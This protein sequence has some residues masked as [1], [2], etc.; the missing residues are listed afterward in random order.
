MVI[1]MMINDIE[2]FKQVV[3]AAEVYVERVHVV[4]I[5]DFYT[6]R[7][8]NSETQ[9]EVGIPFRNLAIRKQDIFTLVLQWLRSVSIEEPHSRR[10]EI[11]VVA[12]PICL[13]GIM[14]VSL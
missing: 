11:M 5:R 4:F 13:N 8:N 14:R 6:T 9:R 10:C 12:K 1:A 7:N 3:V 2:F